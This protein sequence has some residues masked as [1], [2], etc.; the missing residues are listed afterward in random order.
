MAKVLIVDDDLDLIAGNQAILEAAGHDV[1]SSVDKT[2]GMA[3]IKSDS[4]D[5]IILDVNMTTEQE[6]FEMNLE[7]NNNPELKNIPVLMQTGVEVMSTNL[8]VVDMIRE[9]RKDPGY[10]DS[11][12]L[13]V[14]S[15]DGSAGVDYLS[16]DGVS[17]FLPVDG[18]L[19][20][21]VDA[22]VLIS[23]VDRLLNK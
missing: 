14:R 13:L 2:E 5:L 15:V 7:L 23:E 22:E 19:S 3:K 10:K 1:I 6:G 4:P 12:T 18:F 16:E 11:K 21:P 17:I 20:K 8:S 9:M